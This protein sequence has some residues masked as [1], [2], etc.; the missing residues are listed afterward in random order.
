MSGTNT[1]RTAHRA[2]HARALGIWAGVSA[3]ALPTGPVLGGVLVTEVGWRAVFWI[4]LPVVAA[5]FTATIRL[6]PADHGDPGARLDLP[7]MVAAALALGGLVYI[8][9][10]VGAGAAVAPTAAGAAVTA[11]SLAAFVLRERTAPAPMMPPDVVR[12]APFAGTNAVAAAMNFVGIG[13][14][15][16]LTLYLQ[17]LMGYSAILAGAMLLP[18]FTLLAVLAPVT[19]RIVGKTG[20]RPLMLGGLLL[21]AAGGA[22]LLLVTAHGPYPRLLPAMLGLGVGMGL[23]TTSVV[24]A[25]M[26]TCPPERQGLASG[27]N[28]TARQAADALG[29][30]VFG[31]I[32]GSPAHSAFVSG[33]HTIAIVCA[34]LWLAAMVVTWLVVPRE[35]LES[36]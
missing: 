29:V 34:A 12:S 1:D 26:R 25:A 20:P 6:V 16:V 18:L 32:A 24:T 21:G 4:N 19:G 28:N 33:L 3:L 27:T 17:Y 14:I 7:G 13:S 2:E 15:F 10:E 8:V 35:H 23:L 31:A 5:A 9:I 30:A 36:D 22:A 11:L